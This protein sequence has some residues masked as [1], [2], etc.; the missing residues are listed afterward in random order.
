MNVESYTFPTSPTPFVEFNDFNNGTNDDPDAVRWLANYNFTLSS[1]KGKAALWKFVARIGFDFITAG[2]LGVVVQVIDDDSPAGP[3]DL[4]NCFG[5]QTCFMGEG[6]TYNENTIRTSLTPGNDDVLLILLGTYTL[7]IYDNYGERDLNI[8]TCIPFT[9]DWT[10][11]VQEIQE[12]FLSCTAPMLPDTLIPGLYDENGFLH[13]AGNVLLNIEDGGKDLSFYVMAPTYF[14]TLVG[15]HRIDI[16][17]KLLNTDTN[18]LLAYS[19]NWDGEED[20]II[21]FL[22]P[23]NYLLS[24][25]YR[26]NT[27]L[28]NLPSTAYF[29]DINSAKRS[30]SK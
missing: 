9:F 21:Y 19:L 17:L 2:T 12:D 16:D 28:D 22:Q 30:I 13:Y 14:K 1:V 15:A 25:I 20:A 8:T 6:H 24:L 23:G 3:P 27:Y 18:D 7:W 26:P 10:I 4:L 29:Y 11:E 5:S